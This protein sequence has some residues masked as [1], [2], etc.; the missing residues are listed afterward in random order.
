MICMSKKIA[1]VLFLLL[2]IVLYLA[3][4]VVGSD[5]I[6]AS[7]YSPSYS[8]SENSSK[9][10]YLAE[11]LQNVGTGNGRVNVLQQSMLSQ[12]NVIYV[13]QFDYDLRGTS[14]TIPEG[15]ILEFDGGSLHNGSLKG[16]FHINDCWYQIFD[17]IKFTLNESFLYADF[18]R[19]EWFGAKGDY[20]YSKKSG[21][22]DA[23]AINAAVKAALLLGVHKV[24]FASKTYYVKETI[25]I[26]SGDIVLEGV[27]GELREEFIFS[28]SKEDISSYRNSSLISDTDSPIIT[29]EFG[30]THPVVI[31][32]INFRQE[33]NK[34][35]KTTQ[36]KAIWLKGWSGPQSPFIFEY[37]HFYRFR[38]AVY[39][40]SH[41]RLYN[42]SKLI[43]RQCAF[44]MNYWCVYFG[45]TTFKTTSLI[46]R[47][48]TGGFSFENNACHHN[49]RGI[50]VG[51]NSGRAS[52]VRNVFEG[53][54]SSFLNGEKPVED[55]M[56]YIGL[57]NNSSLLF[58]NNY[59]EANTV[60]PIKINVTSRTKDFMDSYVTLKNNFSIPVKP[61][62]YYTQKV[63]EIEQSGG[64]AP[65][66]DMQCNN[67]HILYSDHDFEVSSGSFG[68][69][70]HDNITNVTFTGDC[71]VNLFTKVLPSFVKY[72]ELNKKEHI[73]FFDNSPVGITAQSIP[74]FL[75]GTIH[76][77]FKSSTTVGNTTVSSSKLNYLYLCIGAKVCRQISY[78]DRD[79]P[80]RSVVSFV[81]PSKTSANTSII[82]NSN[83]FDYLF[84]IRRKKRDEN[85]KYNYQFRPFDALVS[86]IGVVYLYKGDMSFY[87]VNWDFSSEN[88]VSQD[89]IAKINGQKEGDKIFNHTTSQTL[90]W[91][92]DNKWVDALGKV[93][94]Q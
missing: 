68:L 85:K 16:G 86:H 30:G 20:N 89:N 62:E 88:V 15:S 61:N 51:L 35:T 81:D 58:E 33:Y 74:S 2:G 23:P 45:E 63:C 92:K 38:Y 53:N 82:F 31:R 66:G 22:N 14:I 73:H 37:C 83:E 90:T 36:T 24:K 64:W 60:K 29:T 13:I 49:V 46:S 76:Y 67:L 34:N 91:S 5:E 50:S 25:S 12:K 79:L 72:T 21:T 69:F 54:L 84:A 6:N 7:L 17:N 87:D 75:E 44:L 3:S 39:V 28:T 18:I 77:G 40:Q 8:I 65:D 9:K 41:D 70:F 26:N 19:P 93:V 59:Y 27:Y 94:S 1:V 4:S 80:E 57:H 55:Y 52:V 78:T 56:N 10:V 47:N 32:N 11:N 42:I 43:I 48:V 71:Y